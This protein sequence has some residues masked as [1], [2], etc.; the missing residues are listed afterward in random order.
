MSS[1]RLRKQLALATHRVQTCLKQL[2]EYDK[3]VENEEEIEIMRSKVIRDLSLLEKLVEKINTTHDAWE[4][5]LA[6][7]TGE[8]YER[9]NK[10]YEEECEASNC[11]LEVAEKGEQAVVALKCRLAELDS[12]QKKSQIPDVDQEAKQLTAEFFLFLT[13][14]YS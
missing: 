9:E 1:A 5:F 4:E 3:G 14:G 2:S 12:M 11:F 13:F 8:A 10:R 6:S 7:L